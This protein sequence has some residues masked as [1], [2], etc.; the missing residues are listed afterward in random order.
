MRPW[1]KP[2]PWGG[3]EDDLTSHIKP[4][5]RQVLSDGVQF[6]RQSGTMRQRIGT[7]ADAGTPCTREPARYHRTSGN[8]RQRLDTPAHA[9]V[10]LVNELS[11]PES[12]GA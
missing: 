6:L 10:S 4:P 5:S 8:Q 12:D 11:E 7:P 9:G 3:S 1:A 2:L